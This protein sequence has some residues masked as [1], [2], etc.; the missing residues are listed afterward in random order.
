[1]KQKKLFVTLLLVSL[2]TVFSQKYL[3]RA[4][5]FQ[6]LT[7]EDTAT[8]EDAL[9]SD[10]ELPSMTDIPTDGF[11]VSPTGKY[12]SQIIIGTGGYFNEKHNL[13]TCV[14][15]AASGMPA[16]CIEP[17][18]PAPSS[19]TPYTEIGITDSASSS[20]AQKAGAAAV[21]MYGYGGQT[22]IN[23]CILGLPEATDN[24]G[25]SYGTYVMDGTAYNGL[26]I[27][28]VF[29]RMSEDEAQAVT[30]AVIHKLNGADVGNITGSHQANSASVASAA[31][32][33]YNLGY[34]SQINT[35]GNG[36]AHTNKLLHDCTQPKRTLEIQIQKQDGSWIDMPKDTNDFNWN[37]YIKDKKINMRVTYSASKCESKLLKSERISGTD[38]TISYTHSHL[39]AFSDTGAGTDCDGYYDYF[40]ITAG[41]SNTVPINVSYGKLTTDSMT[42]L[43]LGVIDPAYGGFP[44]CEGVLFQQTA[45]LSFNAEDIVTGGI[46]DLTIYVPDA[47]GH[48]PYYGDGDGKDGSHVAGRFY[49]SGGYQD[50]MIASPNMSVS[51]QNQAVYAKSTVGELKLYKTSA[52]T[53]ATQKN[54]CYSLS[55]AVYNIYQ[56]RTDA[57]S[58]EN[59]YRQLTTDS[60]GFASAKNLPFGTYYIREA[61]ASKG[62]RLDKTIYSVTINSTTAVRLDVEEEL[63]CDMAKIILYKKDSDNIPLENALFTIKYYDVQSDGEPELSDKTPK[64]TWYFRSDE[65]GRVILNSSCHIGGDS[66]YYDSKNQ[67]FIPLGTITVQET[68]APEGYI[69]DDQIYTFLI[70]NNQNADISYENRRVLTNQKIRQAFQLIKYGETK[71]QSENPLAHAGFMACRTD[72]LS[73]DAGGNYIWDDEQTVTLTSDGS[74]EMF[75]DENGYACSIPLTYGTYIVRETTVPENFVRIE[76]FIV[77]ITENSD[78]PQVMRYFTDK[79]FK[80]YLKI[81]KC[82]ENTGCRIISSPAT[83]KLWSYEDGDYVTFEWE[84]EDG[85]YSTDELQT[86]VS[87]ELITPAPLFP[88]RYRIDEIDAPKGYYSKETEPDRDFEISDSGIYEIATPEDAANADMGIFTYVLNNTPLK[89]QI[90]LYKTGEQ[91]IWNTDTQPSAKSDIGLDITELP[92]SDMNYDIIEIPLSNVCFDII[93][94]DTIYTPDGQKNVLY[95]KGDIVETIV[96]NDAGYAASSDTLSPGKYILREAVPKGYLPAEDIHIELAADGTVVEQENSGMLEKK[97]I[98]TCR[99]HN[100]LMLPNLSTVARDSQTNSHTG[101]AAKNAC[102]IDAISYTNLLPDEHYTIRGI[103]MD[104]TSQ[105]PCTIDGQA[106]T[107]E[108]SF[109][110]EQPDG[111]IDIA[112]NLDASSLEGKSVVLYETLFQGEEIK[113]V[114]ADIDNAEQTITYPVPPETPKTGDSTPFIPIILL[115]SISLISVISIILIK[116]RK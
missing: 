112:F 113:A 98:Q 7:E 14:G 101:S 46:L 77:D 32:Y 63:C 6:L 36:W 116:R 15:P 50:I 85:S 27:N 90:E 10:E 4:G 48:T 45:N 92:L 28:G 57:V 22:S 62:Y 42:T 79:S 37:S 103:L 97:I 5:N 18:E 96:T 68:Q 52:N 100:S 87:G 11:A 66:L 41:S 71:N 65:N 106:I 60:N 55:G 16:Y 84:D 70:K 82:D 67:P 38:G 12:V 53:S 25:G 2:L 108:I 105:A 69:T 44:P 83:F 54:N 49:F 26:L 35:A 78:T 9:I 47:A 75:T 111:T 61:K 110:P 29:F 1:M 73:I 95:G 56:N 33:L 39:T 76:D 86:N 13:L 24:M 91:Q 94:E 17:R 109:T 31:S 93:A 104:K 34:Y 30:A 72:T 20:L 74:K 19:A 81:I 89:G 43:Q 107:A 8:G 80:A 3:S 114:H 21:M 23:N 40:K 115:G 64:K 58:G 51:E 99:L 102:I 88:G 59:P